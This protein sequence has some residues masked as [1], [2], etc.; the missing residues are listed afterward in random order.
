VLLD[1]LAV[2]LAR[3]REEKLLVPLHGQPQQNLGRVD[4]RFDRPDR[5]VGNEFDPYGGGQMVDHVDVADCF[6]QDDGVGDRAGMKLKAGM[7][8][9]RPQVLPDARG[10]VIEDNDLVP[11]CQQLLG[12]VAANEAGPSR[13]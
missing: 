12:E 10:E 13:D 7:R 1:V 2:H 5:V 6:R 8:F 11:S 9:D 4:V 3:G